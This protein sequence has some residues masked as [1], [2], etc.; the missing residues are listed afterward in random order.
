MARVRTIPRWS[1]GLQP[2]VVGIPRLGW[3]N[4]RPDSGAARNAER[5]SSQSCAFPPSG[6]LLHNHRIVGRANA[7]ERARSQR[8]R[9]TARGSGAERSDEP[10][11][12][13]AH[14]D[15]VGS[16]EVAR[17][18]R[19]GLRLT[20]TRHVAVIIG[21][22][23]QPAICRRRPFSQV[24]NRD[25]GN[26]IPPQCS[27]G[28][29]HYGVRPRSRRAVGLLGTTGENCIRNRQRLPQVTP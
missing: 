16:D 7:G 28:D 13:G 24:G 8:L 18:H 6:K 25:P 29:T 1:E 23:D 3:A 21:R 19:A 5:S 4:L 14:A 15:A 12:R 17:D 20:P 26:V 27:S 11:R 9:S 2:R 22:T 10:C